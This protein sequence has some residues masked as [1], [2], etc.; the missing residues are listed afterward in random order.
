M[1]NVPLV[2]DNKY[3]GFHLRLNI[4]EMFRN[5]R[6]TRRD[7]MPSTYFCENLHNH[8]FVCATVV[9]DDVAAAIV[10]VSA[11]RKHSF[12]VSTSKYFSATNRIA[13]DKSRSLYRSFRGF[14]ILGIRKH[15]R[16]IHVTYRCNLRWRTVGE[17]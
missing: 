10:V 12:R 16:L 8:L 7:T 14:N 17:V 13:F 3:H 11:L 1:R 9:V 15:M 2:F 6:A 5:F 4:Y